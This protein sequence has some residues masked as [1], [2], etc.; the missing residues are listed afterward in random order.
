[1][2]GGKI[3]ETG[4]GEFVD[5]DRES[6]EVVASA[7]RGRVVSA[8]ES[9]EVFVD[10]GSTSGG[11]DESTDSSFEE[12]KAPVLPATVRLKGRMSL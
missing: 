3:V 1:M 2:S 9:D 7:A 4:V 8:S 11:V 10:L 6:G 12:I 5:L